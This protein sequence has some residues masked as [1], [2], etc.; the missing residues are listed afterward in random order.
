[1]HS[2]YLI[3]AHNP[4]HI[5]ENIIP[6]I[7]QRVPLKTLKVLR[8]LSRSFRD[9]IDSFL[10][11]IAHLKL[12]PKSFDNLERIASSRL[13][14]YVKVIEY[15]N[16]FCLPPQRPWNFATFQAEFASLWIA[17]LKDR[18]GDQ[19]WNH[20]SAYLTNTELRRFWDR[21]EGFMQEQE[22]VLA[23]QH[24]ML[25]RVLEL[26]RANGDGGV[27]ELRMH[28]WDGEPGLPWFNDHRL[29]PK[30]RPSLPSDIFNFE[31]LSDIEDHVRY[32]PNGP[33]FFRQLWQSHDHFRILLDAAQLAGI[34]DQLTGISGP[35]FYQ[36][37][38]IQRPL[39]GPYFLQPTGPTLSKLRRLHLLWNIIHYWISDR[40]FTFN[41]G[42]I[43]SP[44]YYLESLKL[45]FDQKIVDSNNHLYSPQSD[46][47]FFALV[48]RARPWGMLT[49]LVL[50]NFIVSGPDFVKFLKMHKERLVTLELADMVFG[51]SNAQVQNE[52]TLLFIGFIKTL[53]RHFRLKVV[54]FHGFIGFGPNCWTSYP[55][56]GG[57]GPSSLARQMERY[58]TGQ[59]PFPGE[60]FHQKYGRQANRY[61]RFKM[62]LPDGSWTFYPG[63]LTTTGYNIWEIVHFL[64]PAI[65]HYWLSK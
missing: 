17:G 22:F 11:E 24:V 45:T 38:F 4:R 9:Y 31:W 33:P 1:M 32:G 37:P 18:S 41:L 53:N 3:P 54:F 29:A 23:H 25:R 49:E 59:G 34:T 16:C 7:C 20:V 26:L 19:D 30:I 57:W 55:P 47:D 8:C 52:S 60:L 58:A 2:R 6:L 21:H 12:H 27:K 56:P 61:I 43:L 10:W 51:V 14:R 39:S 48:N 50:H 63:S 40:E 28:P 5:P 36:I 44:S 13:A 46:V 42:G 62:V 15:G 65:L 35:S 64:P